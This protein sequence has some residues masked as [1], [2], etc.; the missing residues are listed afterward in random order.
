MTGPINSRP[1]RC[2]ENTASQASI[3]VAPTSADCSFT[4]NR[5]KN[6]YDQNECRTSAFISDMIRSE[7]PFLNATERFEMTNYGWKFQRKQYEVNGKNR[8]FHDSIHICGD[9]LLLPE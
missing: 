4:R 3:T 5:T 7:F 2:Y 1:T 6:V 9:V 8:T